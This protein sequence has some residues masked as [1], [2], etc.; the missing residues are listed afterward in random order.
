MFILVAMVWKSKLGSA[1]VRAKLEKE[2]ILNGLSAYKHILYKVTEWAAKS[3]V[4]WDD[5]R[6]L[7]T[8]PEEANLITSALANEPGKHTIMLD[9]DVPAKLVES[10]TPGHS[11][12]YIDVKLDWDRYEYLL[13][14]LNRCKIIENG[15]YMVSR[16]HKLTSLRLPWCKKE[17]PVNDGD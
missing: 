1:M 14:E 9:L 17:E 11:H 6:E 12:L 4:E 7:T 13:A 3:Q 8:D 10:S 2:C 16:R 5:T 15:Y